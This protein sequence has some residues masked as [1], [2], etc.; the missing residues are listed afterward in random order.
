MLLCVARKRVVQMR[1]GL[2]RLRTSVDEWLAPPASSAWV[3]EPPAAQ[4]ADEE[5]VGGDGT[6]VAGGS[7][8][9]AGPEPAAADV[10]PP[11]PGPSPEPDPELLKW[12]PDE[13]ESSEPSE[14]DDEGDPSRWLVDESSSS[15]AAPPGD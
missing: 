14:P 6:A 13:L 11:E 3:H 12:L 5:V 9:A 8:D 1:R 4:A 15:A 7:P 2:E 10:A